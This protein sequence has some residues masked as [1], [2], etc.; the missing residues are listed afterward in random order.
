MRPYRCDTG[1]SGTRGYRSETVHA[2]RPARQSASSIAS[3]LPRAS[4]RSPLTGSRLCCR[5]WIKF[6]GRRTYRTCVDKKGAIGPWTGLLRDKSRRSLI[7]PAA[8]A[9]PQRHHCLAQEP[10]EPTNEVGG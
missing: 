1:C 3:T 9:C 2:D 10:E 5:F 8:T 6:L 7:F 4:L